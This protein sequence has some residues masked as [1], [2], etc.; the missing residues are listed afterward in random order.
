MADEDFD[1]VM[2]TKQQGQRQTGRKGPHARIQLGGDGKKPGSTLDKV[3][4]NVRERNAKKNDFKTQRPGK[5]GKNLGG[6]KKGGNS[7]S[8]R[9]GKTARG[10]KGSR[11]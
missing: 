5:K 7:G 11:R 1:K 3:R 9:A 4:E 10:R 8:K 6:G 2:G